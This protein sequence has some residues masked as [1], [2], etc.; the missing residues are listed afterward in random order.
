MNGSISLPST[1]IAPTLRA[2]RFGHGLLLVN[3]VVLAVV[4]GLQSVFDLAGHFLDLGPTAGALYQ[5]PDTIG[6]F[7]A[8]ALAL[9]IAIL[10]LANHKAE[11]TTWHWVAAAFHAMA[12]GANLMFWSSFT[13]Y[14]L[15]PIG[16]VATAMHAVFLALQ[17][18]AALARTPELLHGRGAVFR[19]SALITL[20]TG[21][22][23]HASSLVLGREAFVAQLFTPMFDAFFA[24]PMTIA[25]VSAIW[26]YRSAVFP[27]FWQRAVY[28]FVAFYFTLSF[29]IHVSTLFT[30]DT[31]YVLGFP[32]WY[33]IVALALMISLSAFVIRQRFTAPTGSAQGG[34]RWSV[35]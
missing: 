7:E 18:V 21:M 34:E 8:H 25:G 16:V 24:I 23:M 6:Y 13:N 30:W 17:L 19:V 10:M 9:V 14:G 2:E 20:A 33:P 15:V 22:V 12:G 29:F 11:A 27:A 31:S 4:A 35:S 5:N 28:I 32:S 1:V 26:L 3:G